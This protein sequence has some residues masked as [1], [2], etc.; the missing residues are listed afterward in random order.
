MVAEDIGFCNAKLKVEDIEVFTFDAT[1]VTFAENASTERPVHI[2]ES[3]IIQVLGSYD[4]GTEEDSFQSPFFES[5]MEM[6]FSSVDVDKSSED[7]LD[8]DLCT[9]DHVLDERGELGVFRAAAAGR[10]GGGG[11]TAHCKVDSLCDSID[12]ILYDGA[13]ELDSGKLEE[14]RVVGGRVDK[15]VWVNRRGRRHGS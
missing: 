3:G 1:N 5:D 6:R 2:L 15:R 10:G 12:K 13:G 7:G 8:G 9:L 11:R 14:N 4:D